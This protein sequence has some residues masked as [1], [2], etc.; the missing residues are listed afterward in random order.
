MSITSKDPPVLSQKRHRQCIANA[1]DH[2]NACLQV[3]DMVMGAEHLR[4]AV[5]EIGKVTGEVNPEEILDNLFSSFCIG[6]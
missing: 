1:C 5:A 2:I 6:K 4:K 3:D